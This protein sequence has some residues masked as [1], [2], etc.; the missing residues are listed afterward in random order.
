MIEPSGRRGL[1]LQESASA[2]SYPL[3]RTGFYALRLANG[4]QDLVAANPDR[5]ESDLTPIPADVLALWRGGSSGTGLAA[6]TRAAAT[7]PASAV[8]AP[9]SGAM[10]NSLWWYAILLL[11]VLALAESA[12]GSGYLGTLRDEP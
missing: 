4:R 10:R 3:S 9:P 11:L 8:A 12:V 2:R 1:S 6:A 7:E 5:R